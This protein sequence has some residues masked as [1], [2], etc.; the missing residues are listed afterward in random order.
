[1]QAGIHCFIHRSIPYTIKV[2]DYVT[3]GNCSTAEDVIPNP[4]TI[5]GRT[6]GYCC[7]I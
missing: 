5:A 7:I 2:G 1:M 6:D 3:F 4:A